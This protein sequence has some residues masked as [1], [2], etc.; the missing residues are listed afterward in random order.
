MGK[1]DP[2][3]PRLPSNVTLHEL[4]RLMNLHQI[5]ELAGMIED[6]ER[7]YANRG[8]PDYVEM[9]KILRNEAHD[10]YIERD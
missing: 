2:K 7:A 4:L 1:A 5:E 8:Q 6:R 10:I 3:H 9:V